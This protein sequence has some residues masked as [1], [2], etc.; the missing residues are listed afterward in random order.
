MTVDPAR[1]HEQKSMADRSL[2]QG[3]VNRLLEDMRYEFSRVGP[4][5]DFPAFHD[6]P[7]SRVSSSR[8]QR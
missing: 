6:L 1:D 7:F 5:P 3:L 4:P 2:D 8:R